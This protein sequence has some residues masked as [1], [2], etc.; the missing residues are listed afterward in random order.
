MS[1]NPINLNH[2][3]YEAYFNNW[4]DDATS[5]KDDKI[6]ILKTTYKD[7]LRF[8]DRGDIALLEDETDKYYHDVY[9]LG[10]WGVLGN[11]IY[12]PYDPKTDIGYEF[13]DISKMTTIVKDKEVPLVETF[14]N[15]RNGLDFGFSQ[16]PNAFLRTHYDSSRHTIYVLDEIYEKEM[17]NN[18]V[19]KRMETYIGQEYV[20]CDSSE[21]KSIKELRQAGIRALGAKKGKDSVNFG[22]DWLQRQHIIV[23][24][25]CQNFKNEIQ[26]YKWR[27]DKDGIVIDEPVKKNDHLMDALRYA[28]EDEMISRQVKAVKSIY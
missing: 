2:W 6:S 5:Y 24:L 1:F 3:I 27:E 17:T 9:T 18:V 7:N 13:R 12:K 28:Y 4:A 20:L 22:I 8:L 11:L 26:G 19:A 15:Y 21:P 14:D 23:N 25:K 10:N 16:D